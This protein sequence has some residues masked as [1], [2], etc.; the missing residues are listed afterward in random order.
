MG[1]GKMLGMILINSKLHFGKRGQKTELTVRSPLR[2]WRS[3]L[4]CSAIEEEEEEEEKK[5]ILVVKFWISKCIC[6]NCLLIVSYTPPCFYW[7]QRNIERSI[8]ISQVRILSTVSN[9]EY[10]CCWPH[11][12]QITSMSISMT[13]LQITAMSIQ[14]TALQITA[15]SIS[16]TVLQNTSKSISMTVLRVKKCRYQWLSFRLEQYRYQKLSFRIQQCR[17]QWLSFRVKQCPYQ[18][19]SFRIQ[20]CRYQWLSSEYSNVDIDDCLDSPVVVVVLRIFCA[21]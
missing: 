14:M 3:A 4:D 18:W 8:G 15:M 6:H 1:G 17:Y 10:L 5:K 19:L 11:F 21:P 2:R 7:G 16:I 9:Y 20:Q 12:L 13:V